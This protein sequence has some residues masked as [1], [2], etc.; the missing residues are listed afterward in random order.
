VTPPS[1]R[2]LGR[3]VYVAAVVVLCAAQKVCSKKEP[4]QVPRRT[5]RRWVGWW[6]ESM[7]RS[8]FWK[9][10][11]GR[12]MPPVCEKELPQSL[13]ERFTGKVSERIC[14]ALRFISPLGTSLE[15][16]SFLRFV[17]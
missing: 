14:A 9:T 13:L 1:L 3:R 8:L 15:L 5:I 2:F 12:L 10:A 6:K 7:P 11:R 4:V 17:F 16:S